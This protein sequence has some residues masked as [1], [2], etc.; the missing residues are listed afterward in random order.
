M[1]RTMVE[2]SVII[3]CMNNLKYLYPC[4]HSIKKVT[5]VDF[6][7]IVTA[8]L[9]SK[10]NLER[11]KLDF[12]W[13]KFIESNEIRGFSENNNLAL[14]KAKG[15][16]C[17]VLN[18]DTVMEMPVIDELIRTIKTLPNETAVVSPTFISPNGDVQCCG[19]PYYD[20]KWIILEKLQIKNR[21][22]IKQYCNKS[23]VFQTYNILGAGF[24]IRTDLFRN[25]G[26]FDERYFFCP[27][28]IAVS[29]ELNKRG[30]KCYVNSDVKLIHYEGLTSKSVSI[31]RAATT[32]AARKGEIIFYS[33]GNKVIYV[34]LSLFYFFVN[35]FAFLYHKLKYEFGN[36]IEIERVLSLCCLN[37]FNSIFTNMSP[38]EIFVKYYTKISH[39][40]I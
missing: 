24:L 37:T 26:W 30:Y 20:W 4:L 16:Y 3:V 5:S 14:E 8:Y 27:E 32:P 31:I 1:I 9:F 35:L 34:I 15:K 12:P 7:V 6:E 28:D 22:S 17:F 38:K 21:K 18:D 33:E 10:E 40:C 29:T 39:S 19:R 11:V 13:V 36:R 25:I 23:G 2:C